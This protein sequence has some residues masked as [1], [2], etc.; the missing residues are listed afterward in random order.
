M[1]NL[2]GPVVLRSAVGAAALLCMTL[3]VFSSAAHAQRGSGLYL[4]ADVA[5][6]S[7]SASDFKSKDANGKTDF[8]SALG[9]SL[10]VGFGWGPLRMEGEASWRRTGVDS[11]KYARV[12][13]NGRELM[14]DAVRAINAEDWKGSRTTLGLMANA[15]YDLDVG[16]GFTPYFGGGLGVQYERYKID[17]PKG[18][19]EGPELIPGAGLID[20]ISGFGG[21]DGDWVLAYQFGGGVAYRLM[22]S[23]VVHVG[24]R[25]KGA[26]EPKL[27]WISGQSVKSEAENH[28]FAAGIR[29]GF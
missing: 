28:V 14:P 20:V 29:I 27:N 7:G 24:Y 16:L 4:G 2:A 21:D 9:Y 26:G 22:E 5:M 10:A 3:L 19:P 11:I 13:F 12:T 1:G 25:Y 23:L 8:D 18:V 17:R 6:A 15:W